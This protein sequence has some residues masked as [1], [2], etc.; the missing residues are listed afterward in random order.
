MFEHANA[1]HLVVDRFALKV[2]VVPHFYGNQIL[3]ALIDDALLRIIV[4]CLAERDSMRPHTVVTCSPAD[5][6][7][8]AAA[9]VQE[10]FSRSQSKLAA[11]EVKLVLLRL[12]QRVV[13]RLEV[14]A[15]ID[16]LDVEPQCIERI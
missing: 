5:Q 2:T 1:H 3:Q 11:D 16:T 14:G 4:L 13:R 12:L 7:A 15:G 10:M 8:P 6:G 9:N